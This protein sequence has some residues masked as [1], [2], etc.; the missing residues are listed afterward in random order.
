[1][2]CDVGVY[3]LAVMGVNLALNAA[4]KGYTVCVS[5]RTPSRVDHAIELAKTQGLQEKVV[6]FKDMKEFVEN[7]K[8]P[9][10]II[11]LVQAGA[12]VDALISSLLP[13]LSKGDILVDGGNEFYERTEKRIELCKERGILYL[14]MGVSGGEEGARHGPS[15]MPG[16]VKEAWEAMRPILLSIAAQIDPKKAP[17]DPKG[18]FASEEAE[19]AC[20]TFLGPG[21]CGNF[22]KMVHNGIEY[23]DM[24]LIAEVYSVLKHCYGMDNDKLAELFTQWNKTELESYLVEITSHIFRKKDGD[25]YLVDMILDT[26]GNKGTGKWT[27]QQ[28]AEWGVPV[29]CLA[30]ALDMRYISAHRGL[31]ERLSSLYAAAWEKK[32]GC[33]CA[34]KPSLDDIK[35]AMYLAKICCY[36]QGMHLIAT[37]SNEK[38][39]GLCLAEVSRIWKGGCI[40]RAKFLDVMQ[41]AFRDNPDVENLLLIDSIRADVA[42]H[43][44]GLRRVIELATCKKPVAYEGSTHLL[45][46]LPAMSAAYHYLAAFTS[47]SLPTNLIQAQRDF[48]GAHEFERK[49]NPGHKVHE[50][51]WMS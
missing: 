37:A 6:G 46:S 25:K 45:L 24:Q 51:S 5:N 8:K 40:I 1:M 3:G 22:V 32:E 13:L 33:D 18:D 34:D 30:A 19:N 49:D 4:S 27:V 11:M 16:G 15:L 50:A 41:K 17:K 43:L 14:G 48:F 47:A 26:A 36:A 39:W 20:V 29:P 12:P 44:P 31:R 9:R 42:K 35:S 10:R 23:G 28:A 7:I 2:S 21:G 38:N